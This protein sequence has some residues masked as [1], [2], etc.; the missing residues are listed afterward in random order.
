MIAGGG[1]YACLLTGNT[2]S[3]GKSVHSCGRANSNSQQ[4][5]CSQ[6][7]FYYGIEVPLGRSDDP[8]RIPAPI[9]EFAETVV[10]EPPRDVRGRFGSRSSTADTHVP[11]SRKEAEAIASAMLW[12]MFDAA[13]AEEPADSNDHPSVE[14]SAAAHDLVQQRWAAAAAERGAKAQRAKRALSGLSGTLLTYAVEAPGKRQARA[15][16]RA[17]EQEGRATERAA[18]EDAVRLRATR[19]E[20]ADAAIQAVDAV[21]EALTRANAR[22]WPR[23]MQAPRIAAATDAAAAEQLTLRL[24]MQEEA[25]DKEIRQLQQR[26]AEAVEAWLVAKAAVL[27]AHW[28]LLELAGCTHPRLNYCGRCRPRPR[29]PGPGAPRTQTVNPFRDGPANARGAAMP[30]GSGRE[31]KGGHLY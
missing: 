15:E 22:A 17:H 11:A 31:V 20:E 26:K 16:A 12:E 6:K 5:T 10:C 28:A 29:P 18:L 4:R 13:I 21:K 7:Q 23:R 3:H 14:A 8:M 30:V 27:N 19:S 2:S 9:E 25:E 1:C 24:S